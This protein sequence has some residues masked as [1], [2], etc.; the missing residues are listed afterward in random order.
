MTMPSKFLFALLSSAAFLVAQTPQLSD[1]D[2]N[3]ARTTFENRCSGCHGSDANGGELGPPIAGKVRSLTDAQIATVVTQGRKGMPSFNIPAAEL[4]K[5]SG[6]LRMLEPADVGFKKYKLKAQLA[7]GKSVE[8]TV[9]NESITDVQM[10]G[11]DKKVHLLRRLDGGKFREVT[12]EV[13]WATYNGS[14]TGNRFTSMTQISKLNVRQV[15]PRWSFTLPTGSAL[16]GTP[17]VSEGLMFVTNANECYALDAGNGRVVWHYQ[18]PRTRNL[19]GNA[20]GGNNRGVAVS[21]DKVFMVTDNAHLIALNRVDGSL[22]WDKEMADW[23][24]NYNAT[25]APIVVGDM[26]VSGT[27]GGE[28]GVRGFISAYKQS[29]GERVWLIWTVPA[30]GEK[31]SETWKGNGITHGGAAAWFTGVY[32]AETDTIFW[33]T[34]NPGPD[35]NADERGGDNLYSDSMLALDAK[36][37]KMKWYYQ[38]TPHDQWDWDTTETPI[39]VNA[40]WQ[41]KPRKLLLHGNRN[42]FFYVFDRT[43]GKLL[44]A[45]KFINEMTWST[46]VGP[47]GRPVRVVGQEPTPAGTRVC[48]S[49]DGATNWYSPSY[50]PATGLFYMQ[51]NEKCSIYSLRPTGGWEAGRPFLGGAERT[52]LKTKSQRILRAM[53]IQTGSVKWELPQYGRVESWGGTLATSNGLVFFCDDSGAFA[54]ADAVT[55]KLLWSFQTSQNWKASPMAYQFDGKE[56]IAVAAGGTILSFGLPE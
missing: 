6:F 43:D 46:G 11:D 45:K 7:N 12:S 1:A 16:Q 15:A 8:G 56:R 35:Y 30:P 48:P 53:D 9:V 41:G 25:S 55:G 21:G 26:V 52:D 27:A 54:A 32:D 5:L 28:E 18:R 22:V 4:T 19:V 24:Q 39:V 34:G 3:T 49:Q 31:G 2:V 36:T 44:L 38:T 50:N 42:G 10:V 14:I 17:L 20:A 23:H 13:D 29:T 37:G 33:Q 47:D 40:T 51:T